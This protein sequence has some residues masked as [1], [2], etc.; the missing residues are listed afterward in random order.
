MIKLVGEIS[1]KIKF[2]LRSQPVELVQ[3]TFSEPFNP[4]FHRQLFYLDKTLYC[5]RATQNVDSR[6]FYSLE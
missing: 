1:G 4:G 3:L 2:A 5:R 6:G